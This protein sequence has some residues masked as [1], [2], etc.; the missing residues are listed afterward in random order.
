MG[1]THPVSLGNVLQET[2]LF[3]WSQPGKEKNPVRLWAGGAAA[4][5]GFP[6]AAGSALQAVRAC[7]T[8][9]D[10]EQCLCGDCYR[11]QLIVVSA[12]SS[13]QNSILSVS[14]LKSDSSLP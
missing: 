6:E 5:L 12:P 14:L 2:I 7:S 10:L 1:A 3:S 13:D 9:P 11:A 8:G 4:A